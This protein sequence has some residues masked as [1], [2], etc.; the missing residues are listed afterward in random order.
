MKVCGFTFIR[1]A[2]IYDYPVV[3]AIRSIL[4]LCSEVVVAVGKSEDNTLELVRDID[5][6]KIRIVETEWNDSLRE[7]GQVLALET[8]KAYAALPE[9]CDWAIYIQGDEVL[10]EDGYAALK[11]A[12]EQY[13]E[14]REVDGLLLPY[15]HFY[16]SYDYIGDAADW[17][18]YEIRVVRKRKDIYSYKDAQ[19]FRKGQNEKLQVVKVNAYMHHYGWV[20]QPEA[21]KKKELNFHKYWHDDRWIAENVV[22]AVEFDYNSRVKALH[23]F[24][25]EHPQVM[26]KRIASRNWKFEFDI[27]YNRLSFKDKAKNWLRDKLGID[28]GYRNYRL[29]RK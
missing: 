2:L 15:R 19:G 20:K 23:R 6:D 5:P 25:G 17:Y 1:N 26:E 3:E 8:D 7:G 22:P 9:D 27:A 29:L 14:D 28:L 21:M 11:K 12:M 4:P 10:H 24:T 18:P 13:L 16:G